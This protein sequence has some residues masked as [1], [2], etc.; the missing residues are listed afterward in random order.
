[1][2]VRSGSRSLVYSFLN[3]RL[4]K[5][6][7]NSDSSEL[8]G[9][10]IDP[11]DPM[12]DFL[13]AKWKEEHVAKKSNKKKTK[14]KRKDETPEERAARKARKKE[15]KARKHKS[16]GVKGVEDLLNS[17]ARREPASD[18]GRSRSRTPPGR[19]SHYE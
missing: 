2:T 17:L 4:T 8:S 11:E 10:D 12:R 7:E 5:G 18:R 9:P 16:E 14:G 15:K 6:G 1:M 3:K 13:I 19:K